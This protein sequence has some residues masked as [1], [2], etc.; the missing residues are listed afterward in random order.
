ML[1]I[2]SLKTYLGTK[3]SFKNE[4]LHHFREIFFEFSVIWV[5]KI[6]H[7]F[8]KSGGPKNSTRGARPSLKQRGSLSSIRRTPQKSDK[9]LRTPGTPLKPIT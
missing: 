3:K 7:L 2:P 8:S 4:N 5:L 6:S 1:L 9:Y